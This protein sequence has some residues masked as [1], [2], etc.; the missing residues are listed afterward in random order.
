MT[1]VDR[2]AVDRAELARAALAHAELR[3]GVRTSASAA[4]SAVTSAA[5]PAVASDVTPAATSG[6]ASD[7]P[8]G[9]AWGGAAAGASVHG[10]D[11]RVADE[12]RHL[13]PGGVLRRGRTVTV[14]GSRALLLALVAAASDDGAWVAAVGLPELGLVAAA[15]AGVVLER[16]ALVPDPGIDAPAAVAALLDG[17]DVV[18]VGAR[19][20]LTDA[21]RRRLLARARERGTVLVTTTPWSGAHVVLDATAA[22]WSGAS[23]GAGWLREQRLD[24]ERTGRGG[25]TAGRFEVVLP[26]GARGTAAWAAP[27]RPDAQV[28][29]ARPAPAA[30]PDLRVVV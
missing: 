2:V 22:G 16:L 8:A 23:A 17:V 5:A 25:T 19:T 18:L 24:V 29:T 7:D 4:M 10:P 12:V 1:V 9:E 21:D 20:A 3:T 11:L 30:R 13:L 15:E 14:T 27:V 26:L 28:P 6:R